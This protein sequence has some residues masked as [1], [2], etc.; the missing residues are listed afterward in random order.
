M[1][2]YSDQ[3]SNRIKNDQSAFEL[4]FVQLASVVMGH[5]REAETF[6]SDRETAKNAIEEILKYYHIT[7]G[8]LPDNIESV[9]DQL[10]FFLHPSG[11]KRRRVELTGKWYKDGIG[12]LLGQTHSGQIISLLPGKMS[13]YIYFDHELNKRIKVNKENA[14]N[15]GIDAY[16][17]YNPLPSHKI[18]IVDLLIYM[19]RTLAV[20]DYVIIVATILTATVLGMLIPY[21]N[22]QIFG[23]VIPMG[24]YSHLMAISFLLVGATISTM[25]IR[26]TQNIVQ[27]RISTKAEVAVQSAA[28]SRLLSLPAVFF[29]DYTTGEISQRLHGISSLCTVLIQVIFGAGLTGLFSFVFIGQIAFIAPVLTIPALIIVA[30]SLAITSI[31]ALFEVKIS[32]KQLAGAAKLHGL[33]FSLVSGVQKIKIS[34]SERRAFSKWAKKY[35]ENAALTYAPPIFLRISAVLVGTTTAVGSIVL[36]SISASADIAVAEYMAFAAAYAMLSGAVMSLTSL[37]TTVASIRPIMDLAKP[38]MDVEPET[39]VGKKM[40]N[41]LSGSIEINNVFFRYNENMPYVLNNLS[42]KI[43]K[44]QYVA[45]V[46]ASGCGKST[47]LRLLLGFEEPHRG[48]VYYDA[49]DMKSIDLKSLRKSIGCVIQNGKLMTGSIYENIVVSAPLLTI[50]EAWEAAEM[51]GIAEDIRNMPMGM[52]TLVSDGGGGLSGGQKQRVLI[53]RALA[54][55]PKILLLDE[56]T[57]ALDNITQKHVS[58]SLDGLKCTRIV[59]AHRLSTI[60]QCDRVIM[61]EEG[62]IVEDGTYEQLM[63]LNGKFAELVKRQRLDG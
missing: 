44:G 29:K 13:G 60:R 14:K 12:P 49:Q 52:H 8:A 45:I 63:S 59:I 61:L 40:I 25:L 15:I 30:I 33:V 23:H 56:A 34:G 37:S 27:A 35:S 32:R 21:A 4:S 57:S 19:A 53:A 48:A 47:L 16:C 58:Q 42:L 54:P 28:M 55:K 43:N 22:Q 18:S 5:K 6:L 2:L 36:F 10:E 24:G 11:I 3:I 38:I 1:G 50:D 39:S 17:F 62:K 31:A 41:R 51:A 9:D 46:G 7:P 20:S 26:I